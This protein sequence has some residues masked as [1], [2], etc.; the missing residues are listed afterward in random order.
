MSI[1]IPMAP[2]DSIVIE[3][4]V[5]PNCRFEV[6]DFEQVWSYDKSFD[7]IHGRELEGFVRDHDHVFMQAYDHLAPGGWFEIESIGV[8][9][10]SDDNTHPRAKNFLEAVRLVQEASRTFGK[11]MTTVDTWKTRL[12]KTGFVNVKEEIYKVGSRSPP[13]PS[14]IPRTPPSPVVLTQTCIAPSK[15]L[16]QRPQTQRPRPLPPSQ[17]V[18]GRR[19][20]LLR[21]VHA[22]A[23]L[24]QGGGRH[25]GGWDPT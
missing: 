1:D 7:F 4:R 9:S 21:S 13:C 23:G 2:W 8:Q 11:D 16:A 6:D 19:A 18:R 5:P 17:R 14:S 3:T 25:I 20:L 24:E 15:P 10:T 12:E 22:R